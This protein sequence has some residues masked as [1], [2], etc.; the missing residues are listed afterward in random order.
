MCGNQM[1]ETVNALYTRITFFFYFN[2][3]ING[4]D[5][6]LNYKD[7]ILLELRNTYNVIVK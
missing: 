6:V 4:D 3:A 5:I 7:K 1:C 2:F